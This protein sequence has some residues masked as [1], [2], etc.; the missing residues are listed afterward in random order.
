M[1]MPLEVIRDIPGHITVKTTE[2]CTHL[3]IDRQ[4]EALDKLSRTIASR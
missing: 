1:G 2:R 3:L 4:S